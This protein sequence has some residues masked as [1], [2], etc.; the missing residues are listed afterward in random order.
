MTELPKHE[1]RGS[2]THPRAAA[3][4]RPSRVTWLW[5]CAGSSFGYR[6][7][8]E[9]WSCEGR[10]RG[11]FQGNDVFSSGGTYMGELTD[12]NRLIVQLD[13]R[14]L[15]GPTFVPSLTWVGTPARAARPPLGIPDGYEDFPSQWE[16][17]QDGA[18]ASEPRPTRR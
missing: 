8:D 2:A 9:L 5:T 3:T 10:H 1:R 4:A 7:G 15:R 11:R 12:D 14:E 16:A 6:V 17:P 13:K 18:S